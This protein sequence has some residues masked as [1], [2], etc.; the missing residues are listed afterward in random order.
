MY[1][2]RNDIYLLIFEYPRFQPS[3]KI[4]LATVPHSIP[5]IAFMVMEVHKICTAEHDP[6]LT[7]LSQISYDKGFFFR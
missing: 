7:R 2:S 5:E 6:V 1:L 3:S 4:S